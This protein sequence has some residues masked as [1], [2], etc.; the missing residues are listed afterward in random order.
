MP[1]TNN[2]VALCIR[3]SG[4]DIN[5]LTTAECSHLTG[6]R[7][8]AD[9]VAPCQ[10]VS[11]IPHAAYMRMGLR[12]LAQ[13]P[14]FDGLLDAIQHA[15]FDGT[16][17]RVDTLC[18]SGQFPHSEMQTVIEVANHIRFYPNLKAPQHRFLV[19]AQTDTFWFGEILTETTQ[20]YVPHIEKP[21]HVS[22]SLPARMARA[23]VNLV[24][25]TATSLIDPCCGTGSILLEAHSLGLQ[26]YG[27]DNNP[28]IAG[29]ARRN[30]AHFGYPPAVDY[31]DMRQWTR[32]AAALVTDLPYGKR[33]PSANAIIP[34]L[35]AHAIHLAPVAVY[36][37][38]NDIR[39]W[40]TDAGYR[41]IA[42]YRIVKH[43]GFT[44]Y[45]HRALR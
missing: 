13:A 7:P 36:V 12:R 28:K 23:L 14:T 3:P 40:L 21:Y 1:P 44:R 37:A 33:L 29:M 19:V 27:A 8:D 32:R 24:A 41:D 22:S 11:Q 34:A 2:L 35:L 39:A 31:T 18:L 38:G 26:T 6:G 4:R 10:T 9:G 15:D 45:I 16:A 20:S 5:D 17:F 43:N 42:T 25:P 30:L